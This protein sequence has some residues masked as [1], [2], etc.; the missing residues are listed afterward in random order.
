MTYKKPE[1]PDFTPQVEWC[2][3][4]NCGKKAVWVYTAQTRT[5][6]CARHYMDLVDSRELGAQ[7]A[8]LNT[9]LKTERENQEI[10]GHQAYARQSFAAA[11]AFAK[12]F[13]GG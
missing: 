4:N 12:G 6:L 10:L 7:S 11:R 5:S 1:K 8:R 9:A 13:G 2:Q 3:R